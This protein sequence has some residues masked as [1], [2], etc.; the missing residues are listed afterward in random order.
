MIDFEKAYIEGYPRVY[1][2]CLAKFGSEEFSREIT[3]EAFV[4]AY[5]NLHQLK[6]ESKFIPWVIVIAVHYGYNKMHLDRQR[7]NVLP[8]E[9]MMTHSLNAASIPS[10]R[11]EGESAF[12]RWVMG[13]KK[14]DYQLFYMR[15]YHNMPM[16]EIS[17]RTGRPPG[18]VRRRIAL[19]KAGLK[20]AIERE[21][22]VFD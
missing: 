2:V 6:D 21:K 22:T 18:T 20:V 12:T 8:S 4:R 3:Q 17:A 11:F 7:F 15:Y 16:S 1:R 14:S 9:N 19:L 10:P 5:A 13:L